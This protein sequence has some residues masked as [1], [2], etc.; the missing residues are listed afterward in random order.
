MV[1]M[2]VAV[3][4]TG[5]WRIPLAYYLTDG[6][7]ANLQETLL[8]TVTEKLFESGC[9]AASMFVAVSIT[10]I[11]AAKHTKKSQANI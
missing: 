4:I 9:V 2:V 6:T 8:R 10:I 7:S 3:S 1:L 11:I 5:H